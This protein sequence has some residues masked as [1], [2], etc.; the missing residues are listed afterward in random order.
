MCAS[1]HKLNR[2]TVIVDYN[3]M[4]CYGLTSEVM[5]LEPFADK[6][7]SFG[8]DV[9]EV[10]GHDMSA[11][12]DILKNTPVDVQRPL[13]VICHTVKGKGVSSLEGDASSH[14]KSKISDGEMKRFLKELENC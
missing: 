6:W 4:Q 9:K 8:F 14:H 3:K 10:D 2:L 12:R 7:R 1:K 5:D 13:A 11:L